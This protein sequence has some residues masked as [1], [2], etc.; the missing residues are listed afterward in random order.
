MIFFIKFITSHPS[1]CVLTTE[2]FTSHKIAFVKPTYYFLTL[3][4]FIW[5]ICNK[6]NSETT[7]MFAN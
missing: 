5:V 7:K 4:M 6:Q 3:S 1:V 2:Y